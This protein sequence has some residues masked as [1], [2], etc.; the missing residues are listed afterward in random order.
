[1]NGIVTIVVSFS[2]KDK[3][4]LSDLIRRLKVIDNIDDVR[5]A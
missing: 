3:A 2:V 4:A 5:R 1:K